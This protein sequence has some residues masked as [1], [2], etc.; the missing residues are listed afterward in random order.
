MHCIGNSSGLKRFAVI[1]AAYSFPLI[2]SVLQWDFCTGWLRLFSNL[3]NMPFIWKTLQILLRFVYMFVYAKPVPW[4]KSWG[5]PFKPTAIGFQPLFCKSESSHALTKYLH[6]VSH[7]LDLLSRFIPPT[8]IWLIS[9]GRV[10]Q[11]FNTW[12]WKTM[13]CNTSSMDC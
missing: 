5:Q 8:L 9:I 6:N 1:A 4:L 3:R 11:D 2:Y 12:R 7:S 10:D 13:N